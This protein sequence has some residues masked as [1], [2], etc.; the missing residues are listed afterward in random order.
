MPRLP[1]C[2]L[3]AGALLATLPASAG[4]AVYR[5]SIS[6][7]QSVSWKVDGTRGG[8]E[9]RRG[10]GS[11]KATLRFASAKPALVTAGRSRGGLSFVGSIPSVAKG[12]IAGAFT[13]SPQTP[14]P[15]FEPQPSRSDPTDGCGATKFGVRVDLIAKG[16]FMY[17]TGPSVPLGPVSTAQNTGDCP[18][19]SSSAF[20]DSNDF[21]A[22]GDGRQLWKRSWGIV[23]SGAAGLL[24]SRLHLTPGQLPARR[25]SRSFAKSVAVECTMPSSYSGG[26]RITGALRYTLTLRRI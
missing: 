19:P 23:S 17:A 4:A 20:L 18:S 25:R 2:A 1:L 15:G 11:G 14:C 6:G 12:T 24:A 5:A 10:A 8:C 3:L 9:I 16:A 26:V 21:T 22:C 7:S 13:D